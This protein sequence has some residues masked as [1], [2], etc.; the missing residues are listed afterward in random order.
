MRIAIFAPLLLLAACNV[1]QD[2]N[3]VTVQYDQNTAEEAVADVSNTAQDIG[4][5]IA[6]D[7]SETAAK[8]ENRVGNADVDAD[9]DVDVDANT[10]DN[11]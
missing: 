9:V 6:N 8:V 10:A 3:A 2:G 5:A 7:V 11:R 4:G 1:D